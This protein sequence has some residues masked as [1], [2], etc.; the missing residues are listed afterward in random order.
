MKK[1]LLSMVV[2]MAMIT[3]PAFA[4]HPA[5]DNE[6][7]P[8]GTWEDINENLEDVDS[9]H[10][11]LIF[12]DM[13]SDVSDPAGEGSDGMNVNLDADLDRIQAGDQT[14]EG[15]DN[16]PGDAG[17]DNEPSDSGEV[18]QEVWY[19]HQEVSFKPALVAPEEWGQSQS[20]F[21][22]EMLTTSAVE[23]DGI[24]MLYQGNVVK[25][26]SEVEVDQEDV[27]QLAECLVV[28]QYKVEAGM[29]GDPANYMLSVNGWENWSGDLNDLSGVACELGETHRII[30]HDDELFPGGFQ[31]YF[32][33]QLEDGKIVYSPE[34]FSFTVQ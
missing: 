12:P 4:H 13:D 27:G 28:A 2:S 22:G 21:R 17:E 11:D 14:G 34:P 26:A 15:E 9:P 3:L 24:L 1:I 8:D 25:I 6:N 5:E 16:V 10:L 23:D 19:L 33:Y 30:A 31:L 29:D 18:N 32:G 20:K 7:M